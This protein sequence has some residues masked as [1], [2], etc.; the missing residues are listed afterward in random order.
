MKK[1]RGMIAEKI[2]IH[3]AQ[4]Q[5]PNSLWWRPIFDWQKQMNDALQSRSPA[6]VP[7]AFWD[8]AA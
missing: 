2:A 4:D 5:L 6:I 3:K 1:R 7:S 8:N